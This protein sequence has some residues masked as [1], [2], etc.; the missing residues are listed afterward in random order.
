MKA[1]KSL[2]NVDVSAR[3]F[4]F[5]HDVK[6]GYIHYLYTFFFRIVA[7]LMGVK[8]GKNVSF[9]GHITLDRFKYSKIEIG[10]NC[11]FNSHD[12]FNRRGTNRCILQTRTDYAKIIIG[13]NTGFSGVSIVANKEVR[14]GNNVLIGANVKISD[15]DGHPEVIRSVDEPVIVGDNVFI[16]MNSIILKG[17][18]VGDNSTIGAGSVVTK[19]IPAG[20]IAAGVPCKVIRYKS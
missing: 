15:T 9:N 16:G 11:I 8:F 20:A 10:N 12:A 17:V 4:A 5:I 18:H 1:S 3:V 7:L 13:N 6:R 19:D 2:L 14:I